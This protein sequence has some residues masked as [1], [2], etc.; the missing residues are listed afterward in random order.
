MNKKNK[1]NLDTNQDKVSQND[2]TEL[3]GSAETRQQIQD[4]YMQ[5]TI[6]QLLD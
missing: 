2:Q 4:N 6:D 3:D 5:G 1:A